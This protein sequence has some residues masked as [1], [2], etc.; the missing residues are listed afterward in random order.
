MA[1]NLVPL[2][3]YQIN[4]TPIALNQVTQIAFPSQGCLVRDCS[5]SPDRALSTGVSV[6][7]AIQMPVTFSSTGTSTLFYTDKTLAQ[8]ITL[9]NA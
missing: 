9:F 6:Y 7:T 3:V 5:G 2:N 4:Q 1:T 8:I